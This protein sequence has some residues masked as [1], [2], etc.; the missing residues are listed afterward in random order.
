[1]ITKYKRNIF[2]KRHESHLMYLARLYWSEYSGFIYGLL[3]GLAIFALFYSIPAKAADINMVIALLECESSGR[4]NAIGD[5]G[6]SYGIAQFR[7]ETFYEFTKQSKI[8]G[9]SY[10]NPI[11]QLKIMNWALDNG[12]GYRWTCYRKLNPPMDSHGVR[13]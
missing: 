7:K 13:K 5:D 4:H 8:K 12:Y 10:R 2:A 6:V 11:H 3:S 9:M 1:M